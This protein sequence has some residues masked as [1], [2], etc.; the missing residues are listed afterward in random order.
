[1]LGEGVEGGRDAGPA[2]V[3]PYVPPGAVLV[4]GGADGLVGGFPVQA[5][6]AG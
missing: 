3:E 4:E 2:L 1:M 6:R 5:R